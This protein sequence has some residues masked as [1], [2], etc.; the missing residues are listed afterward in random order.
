MTINSLLTNSLLTKEEIDIIID[1]LESVVTVKDALLS[2][3]VLMYN[4]VPKEDEDKIKL[5]ESLEEARQAYKSFKEIITVLSAKLIKEKDRL[6]V[7]ELC[8]EKIH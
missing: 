6:K 8:N 1:S 7:E 2:Q 5:K 4:I 3:A